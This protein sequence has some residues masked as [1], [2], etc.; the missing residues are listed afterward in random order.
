MDV[1]YLIVNICAM[2]LS[3]VP[4][5][6]AAYRYCNCGY[7]TAYHSGRAGLVS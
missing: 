7:I 3:G 4:F 6:R 5:L 1:A 2:P